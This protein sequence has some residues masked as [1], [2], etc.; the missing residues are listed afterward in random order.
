MIRKIRKSNETIFIVPM[1]FKID[2]DALNLVASGE[3]S[4]LCK[5]VYQLIGKRHHL[6]YPLERLS[7]ESI[8]GYKM[9][10]TDVLRLLEEAVG[11]IDYMQKKMMCLRNIQLKASNIYMEEGQFKFIY[12]PLQ[13]KRDIT[14][15]DFLRKLLCEVHSSDSETLILRRRINRLETYELIKEY[16]DTLTTGVVEQNSDSVYEIEETTLLNTDVSNESE[17]EGETTILSQQTTAFVTNEFSECETTVLSGITFPSAKREYAGNDVYDLYLLRIS[18]GE[19]IHINKPAYSIGKDV[20]SMDYV[21]G[22]E[23]VSRNHATIYLEE[24]KFYLADNGSTNGT[25]LEGVRIGEGERVELEDG[26]I[27]SL[28][29]EVFQVFLER[30]TL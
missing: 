18:T 20:G 7:L 17:T 5:C 12:L 16:I 29:N 24:G 26:Y 10:Y 30:K 28:G 1:T 6:I 14:A 13:Q 19:K 4:F 22:N 25:T 27:I 9:D 11:L 15:R 23:S 8:K 21:L 3:N 2:L